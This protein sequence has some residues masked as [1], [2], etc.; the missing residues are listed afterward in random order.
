[1]S[2][3]P[4]SEMVNCVDQ[5]LLAAVSELPAGWWWSGG[6]CSVSCH[7]TIGPDRAYIGQ[8]ILNA[9]D[10]GFDA[11][12]AQPATLAEALRDCIEQAKTALALL[13]CSDLPE[14]PLP[15]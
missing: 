15:R 9:F 13:A 14:Q 10:D 4:A 3:F 1:M 7:A 5:D 12:L 2:E 6:V 8:P 11:D